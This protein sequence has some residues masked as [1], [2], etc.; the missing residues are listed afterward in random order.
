[1]IPLPGAAI[2]LDHRFSSADGM[3]VVLHMADDEWL[4]GRSQIAQ[5]EIAE[6]AMLAAR[7]ISIHAALL[8]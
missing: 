8:P 5:N 3:A 1:L 2:E 6:T 7:R 4:D